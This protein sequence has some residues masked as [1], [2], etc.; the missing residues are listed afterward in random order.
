MDT[1]FSKYFQSRET[2]VEAAR[3]EMAPDV[4]VS[5]YPMSG[6]FMQYSGTFPWLQVIPLTMRK[7]AITKPT[8]ATNIPKTATQILGIFLTQSKRSFCSFMTQAA[9]KMY[10]RGAA[11]ITPWRSEYREIQEETM[12]TCIKGFNCC[13][14]YTVCIYK[15]L[16]P[17]SVSK[18]IILLLHLVP[19]NSSKHLGIQETHKWLR[20]TGTC[21]FA[22]LWLD[23]EWLWAIV[24]DLS[25]SASVKLV[26]WKDLRSDSYDAGKKTNM[27]YIE[28]K[29]NAKA[30][31]CHGNDDWDDDDDKSDHDVPPEGRGLG[32]GKHCILHNL[33]KKNQHIKSIWSTLN[34][35]VLSPL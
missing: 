24:E 29:D 4:V 8:T 28:F 5:L 32:E 19:A 11:A 17:W 20:N 2:G 18:P 21:K 9:G 6:Q 31:S 10:A 12:H 27:T 26:M 35:I 33:R 30:V 15:P 14:F 25:L 34:E 3:C 16:I 23:S 13:C 22:I 1:S 7:M